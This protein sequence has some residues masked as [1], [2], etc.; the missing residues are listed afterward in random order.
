MEHKNAIVAATV[1]AWL[2]MTLFLARIAIPALL[3]MQNDAI[4]IIA[5]MVGLGWLFISYLAFNFVKDI[6]E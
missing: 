5:G 4:L 2:L 6:F 1:I 3:N